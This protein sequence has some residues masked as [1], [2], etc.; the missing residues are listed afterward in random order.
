MLKRLHK[1]L[2][3]LCL[4]HFLFISSKANAYAGYQI[5]INKSNNKLTVYSNGSIYKTYPVA[6]GRKEKPT[7]EGTFSLV[8]K[9][10]KPGYKGIPGGN[11]KNPLGERWLGLKI[12]KD[13]GRLYG[14]HGTNDPRSIGTY[15]SSGCIRMYNKDVI[16]LYNLVSEGI[17]VWIHQG[18]SQG[19]WGGD[20]DLLI[21]PKNETVKVMVSSTFVRT[22]PSQGSFNLQQVKSGTQL[23][24]IGQLKDWYQ[25]KLSNQKVG[26]I[27]K[28]AVQIMLPPPPPNQSKEHIIITG[29]WVNIRS[30][31][32]LRSRVLAKVKVGTKKQLTG[33]VKGWFQIVLPNGNTGYI[34]KSLASKEEI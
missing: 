32:S 34:H 12:N 27:H 33:E 25:V 28:S 21:K 7:P 14:I 19:I 8:V 4:I 30:K 5:E 23:K 22:G 9:I 16:D 3:F 18:E 31:P 24:W 10:N 6:T 15:A 26:F 29:K 2:L 13:N 20:P 17:P 1:P 11:P